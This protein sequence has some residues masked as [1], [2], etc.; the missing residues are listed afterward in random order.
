V[1]NSGGHSCA[2]ATLAAFNTFA[3]MGINER[4]SSSPGGFRGEFVDNASHAENTASERFRPRI[5][6]N[7]CDGVGLPP[8]FGKI[9]RRMRGFACN[10]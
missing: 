5:E 2:G 1:A 9:D 6:A 7:Q 8:F 4:T 3:L 10:R